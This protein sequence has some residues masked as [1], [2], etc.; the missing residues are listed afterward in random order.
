MEQTEDVGK[1]LSSKYVSE[2]I[3]K[4]FK[5]KSACSLPLAGILL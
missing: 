2:W 5:Q 1:Q 3:C 4:G